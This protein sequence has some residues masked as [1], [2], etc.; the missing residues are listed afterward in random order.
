[1]RVDIIYLSSGDRKKTSPN[2][3]L[4]D[5]ILLFYPSLFCLGLDFLFRLI[6]R[7]FVSSAFGSCESHKDRSRR[8]NEREGRVGVVRREPMRRIIIHTVS[9]VA[10][11]VRYSREIPEISPIDPPLGPH[12]K[13]K[14]TARG[15]YQ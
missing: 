12:R 11:Y 3:T 9:Y 14:H 2:E 6:W 4:G 15:G 13:S 5:I 1:M 10:M 8:H 7:S